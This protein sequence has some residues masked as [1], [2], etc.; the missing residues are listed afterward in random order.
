MEQVVLGQAFYLI[1]SDLGM[2]VCL[3]S[4]Y[5]WPGLSTSPEL[6]S[7]MDMNTMSHQGVGT[8]RVCLELK[9]HAVSLSISSCDL[10]FSISWPAIRHLFCCHP[11]AVHGIAVARIV[12]IDTTAIT[13]QACSAIY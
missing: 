12:A 9:L 1:L 5:R 8:P 4:K 11:C 3:G 13:V 2:I 7:N 6:N 10:L